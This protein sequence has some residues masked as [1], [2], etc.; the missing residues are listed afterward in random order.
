M[1]ISRGFFLVL[2]QIDLTGRRLMYESGHALFRT[3]S[4]GIYSDDKFKV[5]D[6]Q[7]QRFSNN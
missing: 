7:V 3:V 6:V 4:S 2:L 1:S 5:N